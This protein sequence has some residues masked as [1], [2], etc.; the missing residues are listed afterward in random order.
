[1]LKKQ[2]WDKINTI[3]LVFGFNVH[4]ELLGDFLSIYQKICWHFSFN[5]CKKYQQESIHVQNIL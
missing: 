3:I 5:P 2:G 4:D 1:M